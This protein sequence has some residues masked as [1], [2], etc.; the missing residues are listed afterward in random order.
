M[1]GFPVKITGTQKAR[2]PGA[3]KHLQKWR[4][5]LGATKPGR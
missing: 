2:K 4:G 1:P 5:R 3:T